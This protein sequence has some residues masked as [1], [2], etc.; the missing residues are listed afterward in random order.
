MLPFKSEYD[1][2]HFVYLEVC[3]ADWKNSNVIYNV[4]VLID[5]FNNYKNECFYIK[6]TLKE[7]SWLD[8][9]STHKIEDGVGISYWLFKTLCK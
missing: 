5:F 4:H 3:R 6:I 9:Q 8:V 2:N 7:N 1:Y